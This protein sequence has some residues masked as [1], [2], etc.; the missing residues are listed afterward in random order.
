MIKKFF[1]KEK[2]K[3][4]EVSELNSET[5][6]K[7]RLNPV[8]PD[9]EQE[10]IK[11]IMKASYKP[12]REAES[13]LEKLGYKYD[14]ELSSMENKVFIDSKT[15][16]PNI[17]YRGSTRVKDW[18]GNL[19]LALGFKD[20]DAEKRIQLADQVKQKYGMAPDVY[21]H[22]RGGFLAEKASEKTGGRAITYNK[23]VV[24]SISEMFKKLPENQIDIRTS[25]DIVSLPSV[26]QQ[27]GTQI[28]LD[29][30]LNDTILSAHSTENL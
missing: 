1:Q 7:T 29:S 26:F 14:P 24:P 23:A 2:Q 19:K 16:K 3:L 8:L 4:P 17:A 13:D 9:V 12:Q 25:K 28:T 11:T 18:G 6:A 10:R 27:G 15:G 20:K 5:N 21:G 22:S 30:K